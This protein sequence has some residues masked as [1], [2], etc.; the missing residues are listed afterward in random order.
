MAEFVFNADGSRLIPG[1][2]DRTIRIWE[3][4]IGREILN[5]HRTRRNVMNLTFLGTGDK[6][7]GGNHSK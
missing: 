3:T 7:V 6:I 4:E 5:L 1:G 2:E